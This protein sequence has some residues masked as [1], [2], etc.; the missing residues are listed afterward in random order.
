MTPKKKDWTPGSYQI[1]IFVRDPNGSIIEFVSS[2][3]LDHEHP[4]VRHAAGAVARAL[5]LGPDLVPSPE[6]LVQKKP[7]A[8]PVAA[9]PKVPQY[10]RHFL[11]NERLA[12]GAP[13]L[14]GAMDGTV[15]PVPS[16]VT[17]DACRGVMMAAYSAG[18]GSPPNRPQTKLEAAEAILAPDSPKPPINITIAVSHRGSTGSFIATAMSVDGFVMTAEAARVRGRDGCVSSLKR[19]CLRAISYLKDEVPG[20]ITFSIQG[21]CSKCNA[22]IDAK[23]SICHDCEDERGP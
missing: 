23:G 4:I 21:I 17:C 20:Q 8:A 16:E 12:C 11:H 3:P 18:A 1:G 14:L 9:P 15:T 10:V 6:G 2:K 13:Y 5:N 19:S 7:E 22:L